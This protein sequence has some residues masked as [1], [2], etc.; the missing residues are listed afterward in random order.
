MFPIMGNVKRYQL[1]KRGYFCS[2]KTLLII[3][4][5]NKAHK[6]HHKSANVHPRNVVTS[7]HC[8]HLEMNTS[9]ASSNRISLRVNKKVYHMQI[10]ISIIPIMIACGILM[11]FLCLSM[12]ALREYIKRPPSTRSTM[13]NKWQNLFA[14]VALRPPQLP[15]FFVVT[16]GQFP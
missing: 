15:F 2:L 5:R 1:C 10:S 8:G 9:V 3:K 6:Q 7:H 13:R 11:R 14:C 4:K 12:F 16:G